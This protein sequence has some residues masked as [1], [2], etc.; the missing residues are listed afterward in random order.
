VSDKTEVKTEVQTDVKKEVKQ[1][2]KQE[3]KQ[4]V[5]TE[6]KDNKTIINNSILNVIENLEK[7]EKRLL[8]EL[9]N[10]RKLIKS[11]TSILEILQVKDK[12]IDKPSDKQPIDNQLIDKNSFAYKVMYGLSFGKT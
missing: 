2:I 12:T 1:E 10:V 9:D 7:E 5:K 4:E 11:Q 3:V 6:I 8:L